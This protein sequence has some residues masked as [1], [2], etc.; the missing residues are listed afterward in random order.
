MHQNLLLVCPPCQAALPAITMLPHSAS[1][2]LVDL[3]LGP[4]PAHSP[5]AASDCSGRLQ[6]L[7]ASCSQVLRLDCIRSGLSLR[8]QGLS[9]W[10]RVLKPPLCSSGF[11]SVLSSHQSC[12]CFSKGSSFRQRIWSHILTGSPEAPCYLCEPLSPCVTQTGMP[13]SGAVR[14]PA[15]VLALPLPSVSKVHPWCS[16]YC[17]FIPFYG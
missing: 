17:C 4:G 11:A 10:A 13:A 1:G 5:E 7:V 16:M 12:G 3:P 9:P 6:D 8:L 15:M 2:L 14:G